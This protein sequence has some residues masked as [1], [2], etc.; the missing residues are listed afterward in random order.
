[1]CTL[2]EAT[3]IRHSFHNAVE[4]FK[5][6]LIDISDDDLDRN[7]LG[8]WSV[9]DLI[10]HTSRALS[11]IENYCGHHSKEPVIKGPVEY[12]STA[13]AL[14]ADKE[15]WEKRENAIAERGKETGES[16][17]RSPMTFVYDLAERVTIIVDTHADDTEVATPF[18][19]M[20][21]IDYL[22]TRT[23]ELTI[24]SLDLAKA[25]SLSIPDIL[26]DAIHDS[27]ILAGEIAAKH[28]QSPKILLALCGRIELPN[29]LHIV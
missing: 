25:L 19:Q 20:S 9:R 29:N 11:T 5:G 13:R 17:G 21:L 22:P 10:G 3:R 26:S 2:P 7:G 4:G 1:M 27:L 15:A 6:L 24:H 18:G 8:V 28:S 23:F 12:F 14:M 16:M